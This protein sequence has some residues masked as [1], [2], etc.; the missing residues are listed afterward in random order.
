LLNLVLTLFL[1]AMA[2]GAVA[3]FVIDF[4]ERRVTTPP[5]PPAPLPP[6]RYSLAVWAVLLLLIFWFQ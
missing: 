4:W 5:P 6:L 3:V 2:I 1:G